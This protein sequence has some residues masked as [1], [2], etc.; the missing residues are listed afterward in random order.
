MIGQTLKNY[1]VEEL[2]GRGGMGE[3]YRALD[4]R[5]GRPVALKVLRPEVVQDPDRRRR[6]IQEARAASAVNH[7][8][9]AQIYEIEESEATTFISMEYVD[10]S[11]VRK[12]IERQELDLASALEVGIQVADGLARAHEA[13][14]VHRDIKSDNVMVTRDGHPKILDFGLAKLLA[15]EGESDPSAS[16]LE[17][18]TRT[19]AG[20]ILG[21]IHYMSP[22]QAR[23]LPTDRR[24]DVFSFGVLLYEMVSGSLPFKGASV[25]D[26]LHAIAYQET[27]PISALKANMPYSLQKVIDRCLQKKPEERYPDLREAVSDLKKVKREVE[28]GVTGG[29]PLLERLRFWFGG[30]TPKGMIWAAVAGAVAGGLFFSWLLGGGRRDWGSLLLVALGAA[31]IFRRFRNRGQR[32][33]RKLVKRIS[34][35]KEVRLITLHKGQFTVVVEKPTAKTYLRLNALLNASNERLYHGDPMTLVV[36]EGMEEEEVRKMLSSPGVQFLREDAKRSVR[37]KAAGT[38]S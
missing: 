4:T 12:L 29:V 26:T 6:F 20:V 5:L 2:L 25:L 22:E 16:R 21:T 33:A 38:R 15:P 3:V 31:F 36:K 11:T 23:G 19:Q 24:S 32:E 7:P 1:R 35:M 37:L 8:A 30:L 14:I 18:V 34:A 27:R 17:T 13:G 9:I 28:S 10:G